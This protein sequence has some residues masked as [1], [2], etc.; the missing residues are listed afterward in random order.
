MRYTMLNILILSAVI[1]T[2]SPSH[3][4]DPEEDNNP[5][6]LTF[7]GN[8]TFASEYVLRGVT[9]SDEGPVLQGSLGV[10]HDSGIY[11]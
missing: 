10:S 2:V 8:V 5:S 11:A 7:S 1:L 4:Q 3:A 6:S 9:Q